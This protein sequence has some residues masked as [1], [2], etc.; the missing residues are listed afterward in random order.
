[1]A[2]L[3]VTSIF[4]MFDKEWDDIKGV[5]RVYVKQEK[6]KKIFIKHFNNY[7]AQYR[8]PRSLK[9][10]PKQ[11]VV[12]MISNLNAKGTKNCLFYISKNSEN[13]LVLNELGDYLKPSEVYKS[14][15]KDFGS[16]ENS[17]DCWHLVFSVKDE[18]RSQ[19]SLRAIQNA[20]KATMDNNF[21]GYKFAMCVHNHQNNPHVHVVINKRNVFTNK[22]IHFDSRDEIK[23]F[24]NEVRD[25]YAKNLNAYGF[26]YFN[27]NAYAK[28]LIK[29]KE[30]A[31]RSLN[32]AYDTKYK[33]F[34]VFNNMREI[35]ENKII[36]KYNQKENVDKELEQNLLEHENLIKLLNQ[37]TKYQV[38][39]RYKVLADIKKNNKRR[40]ELCDIGKRIEKELKYIQKDIEK[41]N[42]SAGEIYTSNVSDYNILKS[43]CFDFEKRFL[44]KADKRSMDIYFK[45]KKEFKELGDKIDCDLKNSVDSAM[46]YQKLFKK[47]ENCFNIIK[48]LDMI[49]KN[50]YA[51][52]V[53][54]I[55]S[56]DEKK[57]YEKIF[58]D[59]E[60][61]M[62]G[63]LDKRFEKIKEKIENSQNLSK[64]NFLFKE[65]HKAISYLNIDIEISKNN[66]SNSGGYKKEVYQSV[67]P[68]S[69]NFGL[70]I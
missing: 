65:Y 46:L 25:E 70:D 14:W 3:K 30:K 20:V 6:E 23:D 4:S 15:Q 67:K 29:E 24:F 10:P 2:T 52:S 35:D 61:F 58:S 36:V 45:A 18:S 33:F 55:L 57:G 37:Y 42:K 9:K 59:N 60:K 27:V 28:D 16:N 8:S 21:F 68:K 17:K 22:K 31:E 26:N 63:L 1:M 19:P 53:C 38:K 11:C 54:D 5:K 39:K 13:N 44:K 62:R 41:I 51:L 48:G 66:D 56:D 34:N 32:N 7:V 49:E 69:N 50:K 47:D 64:D 43:F 12:K 40:K